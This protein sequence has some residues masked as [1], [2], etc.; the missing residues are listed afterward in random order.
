MCPVSTSNKR[1][2]VIFDVYKVKV[3]LFMIINIL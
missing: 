1:D 2:Y 3:A